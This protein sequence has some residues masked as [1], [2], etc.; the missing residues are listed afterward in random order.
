MAERSHGRGLID[1]SVVI[2]LERVDQVLLPSELA[3]SAVTWQNLQPARI[4]PRIRL[5]V[6]A[7]RTGSNQRRQRSSRCLWMEESLAPMAG[8]TLPSA[9]PDVK[10]EVDAPSISQLP[11]ASDLPLHTRTPDDFA[12]LANLIE[13]VAV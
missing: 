11:L 1:T 9:L 2:H 3:I 13:V 12:E 8:F 6:L 4:R 7:G 5:S 10:R